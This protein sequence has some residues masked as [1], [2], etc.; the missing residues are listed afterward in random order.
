[1]KD[2]DTKLYL[3][4]DHC[5]AK[6]KDDCFCDRVLGYDPHTGYDIVDLIEEDLRY[7]SNP[8]TDAEGEV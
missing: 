6:T 2:S 4:C 7:L 8:S 1:M 3:Y 5:N